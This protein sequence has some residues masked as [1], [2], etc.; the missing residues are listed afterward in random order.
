MTTCDSLQFYHKG[1][2]FDL[3]RAKE[4]TV[5]SL[6]MSLSSDLCWEEAKEKGAQASLVLWDLNFDFSSVALDDPLSF[7]SFFLAVET[8]V[9]ELYT[10]FQDKSFGVCLYQG[11]L[12]PFFKWNAEH[13]E[14]F[15]HWQKEIPH[16]PEGKELYFTELFSEYLHRLAAALPDEAL[17]LAFF[18]RPSN[19]DAKTAQLL[20]RE[21]FS[22]LYVGLKEEDFFFPPFNAF[23][24]KASLGLVQ[25]LHRYCSQKELDKLDWYIDLLKGEKTHFRLISEAYLTESWDGLDNLILFSEALSSQG[26]RKV[27][28]FAAAGGRV[29]VVGEPLGIVGEMS[30][31]EFRGRGI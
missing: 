29:I 10:P 30:W 18:D 20:S 2:P 16:F 21:H 8:F 12:R 14:N 26:R 28:G 31:D 15:F 19:S 11:P 17:P 27:Q 6:D 1:L 13:E 9:K 3:L 5:I 25:P 22:Y 7:S 4:L 24:G 23:A